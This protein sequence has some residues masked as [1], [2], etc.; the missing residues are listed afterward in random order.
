[1]KNFNSIIQHQH[2]FKA[3]TLCQG[4]GLKKKKIAGVFSIVSEN[5]QKW[6]FCSGLRAVQ[7]VNTVL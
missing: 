4:L 5:R 2:C 3:C 7:R 6:L 1:M